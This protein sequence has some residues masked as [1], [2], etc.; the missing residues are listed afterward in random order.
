MQTTES[1]MNQIE[2]VS[3]RSANTVSIVGGLTV[4][5]IIRFPSGNFFKTSTKCASVEW[6]RALAASL[7]AEEVL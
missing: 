6:A 7:A 2:I 3:S 4:V 5:N 1:Q